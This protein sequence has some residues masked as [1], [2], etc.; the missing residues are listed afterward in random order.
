MTSPSASPGRSET[1]EAYRVSFRIPPPGATTRAELL[2]RD[3]SLGRVE[4]SF[5]SRDDFFQSLRLQMPTLFA[6]VG[7][8]TVACETFV[9]TQ[10]RG[11]LAGA[12][13]TSPTSLAPLIDLDL[14]VE[15]RTEGVGPETRVPA[16]LCSSQLG[17]RQ[18]LVTAAL[19]QLPRRLGMWK[20]TWSLGDSVLAEPQKA[21][22]I[23]QSRFRRSLRLSD[24]R[25]VV[26]AK[27][28][29]PLCVVRQLPPLETVARVGPCFLVSSAEKGVA[30]LCRL[31]VTAQVHGQATP[32]AP[33]E[34]EVLITDGPT[35]V[36]PGTFAVADLASVTAFELRCKGRA[37]GVQSLRPA[38]TATFTAEGGFKPTPDY[39]WSAAAEEEMNERLNRLLEGHGQ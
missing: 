31:Q 15:F 14:Q 7:E 35:M 32:P 9:A 33:L 5:L 34:Q 36:A 27:P 19:R 13:L 28:G 29:G 20:V 21:R 18:A 26:Q 8:C 2:F 4:L 12:V 17:G 25:F 39:S 16:R 22:G 3:K 6:R 37:L 24:T 30:G 10:C 1:T 11:L 38:P 23:S